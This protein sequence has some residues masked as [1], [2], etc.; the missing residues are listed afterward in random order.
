MNKYLCLVFIFVS[1]SSLVVEKGKVVKVDEAKSLALIQIDVVDDKGEVIT[2]KCNIGYSSGKNHAYLK[3]KEGK[4]TFVQFDKVLTI[5]YINCFVDFSLKTFYFDD[6]KVQNS[7]IEGA[8]IGYYKLEYKYDENYKKTKFYLDLE[9]CDYKK[10]TDC[11]DL[12]RHAHNTGVISLKDK[13]KLDST[14]IREK[15]PSYKKQ[16]VSYIDI[17][18]NNIIK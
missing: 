11:K 16:V 7:N 5:N 17:Y 12:P 9:K 2:N 10:R 6:F 3:L 18:P 1:C 4:P 8:N 15:F 14:I 13:A